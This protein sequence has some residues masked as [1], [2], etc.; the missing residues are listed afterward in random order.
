M[1][2]FYILKNIV[3]IGSVFLGMLLFSSC[4]KDFD[5]KPTYRAE[6]L[7]GTWAKVE[8]F[9]RPKAFVLRPNNTW[10]PFI[11]YSFTTEAEPDILGFS[12][13][14]VYIGRG[15]NALDILE[16][17]REYPLGTPTNNDYTY[18]VVIP[19]CFKFIPDEP[20]A[21][22]GNVE[23]IPQKVTVTRTAAFNY[24]TYQIP[25]RP[26]DKPGRFDITTKEFTIEVEFDDTAVGGPLAV[27]RQ[28]KFSQ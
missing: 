3:Y 22:K 12:N 10:R 5:A 14:Y 19:K 2:A 18:N 16:T 27:R 20:G 17:Y 4:N 7:A 8:P 6:A 9:Y 23:V 26:S 21:K 25:M 11:G 1:K 28:Y 24:S 15:T 13:P